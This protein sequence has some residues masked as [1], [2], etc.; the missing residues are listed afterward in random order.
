MNCWS[1]KMRLASWRR[2]LKLLGKIWLFSRDKQLQ[3]WRNSKLQLHNS[4]SNSPK[5]KPISPGSKMQPSPHKR[6]SNNKLTTTSHKSK[7]SM[8]KSLLS[9]NKEMNLSRLKTRSSKISNSKSRSSKR[10]LIHLPI[11]PTSRM[12]KTSRRRKISLNK[13]H[14]LRENSKT[15]SLSCKRSEFHS[16]TLM[17]KTR[18][19]T[20][21]VRRSWLKSDN[22]LNWHWRN[23]MNFKKWKKISLK[24][25]Q[26][27][28]RARM[29]K[30]LWGMSLLASWRRGRLSWWTWGGHYK[31]KMLILR[32]WRRNKKMRGRARY[33]RCSKR[34]VTSQHWGKKCNCS[35]HGTSKALS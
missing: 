28:S 34:K 9:K 22:W 14:S 27:W 16:R 10:K 15:T 2:R 3:R 21:I 24:Q 31:G 1:R 13:R 11:K 29:S 26:S 19:W 4:K 12:T 6:L 35:R 32:G 5:S 17:R 23:K 8:P 25:K 33:L 20:R 30:E 7:L 18:S